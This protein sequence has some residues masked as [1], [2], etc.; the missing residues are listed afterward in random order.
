MTDCE[1][2]SFCHL[3]CP[4]NKLDC[5]TYEYYCENLDELD[6]MMDRHAYKAL[7]VK[8]CFRGELRRKGVKV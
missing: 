2:R 3:E 6:M 7:K 4:E 8:Q 1:Y 5:P